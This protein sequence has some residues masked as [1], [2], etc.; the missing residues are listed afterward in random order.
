M[1]GW[2]L[3]MVK[4][5]K[6]MLEEELFRGRLQRVDNMFLQEELATMQEVIT[7]MID[8]LSVTDLEESKIATIVQLMQV[9]DLV[10]DQISL[11]LQIEVL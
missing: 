11:D 9:C 2:N 7:Q 4:S 3:E 6:K 10:L 8:Q 5:K 1:R